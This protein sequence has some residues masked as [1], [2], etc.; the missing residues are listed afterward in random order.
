MQQSLI[1]Q[2]LIYIINP[3]TE[4]YRFKPPLPFLSPHTDTSKPD[5]EM[6]F[7]YLVSLALA[8]A[9]AT[10]TPVSLLARDA[11]SL[12]ASILKANPSTESC[13][14]ADFPE[15]CATAADAAPR[16]ASAMKR[17]CIHDK[18]VVAALVDIRLFESGAF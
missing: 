1:V 2:H 7:S 10:A 3:K 14:E 16:I 15:E 17:F 12:E 11:S 18:P 4:E 6:Q 9:T 8:A 13:A 5:I